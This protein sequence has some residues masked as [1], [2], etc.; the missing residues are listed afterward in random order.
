MDMCCV[1]LGLKGFS[2]DR[3]AEFMKWASVLSLSLSLSLS[4]SL[5]IYLSIYLSIYL[6][7]CV[8]V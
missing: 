1:V 2:R 4:I 7:L 3:K 8:C 5:Y 6:Y